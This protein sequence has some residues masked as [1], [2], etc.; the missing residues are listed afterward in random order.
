MRSRADALLDSFWDDDPLLYP[1]LLSDT[2]DDTADSALEEPLP[3]H[4]TSRNSHRKLLTVDPILNPGGIL[5]AHI[6]H[7]YAHRQEG[8]PDFLVYALG[9]LCSFDLNK[10]APGCTFPARTIIPSKLPA[11]AALAVSPLL[12]HSSPSNIAS[13]M[14]VFLVRKADSHDCRVI[15]HPKHLNDAFTPRK[16]RLCSLSDIVW[17]A[18]LFHHGSLET[19]GL[20]ATEAD[21]KNFFP[22]IPVS[23]RL[24][25]Y[26]GVLLNGSFFVQRCLTQGWNG[27]TFCAQSITW[28]ILAFTEKN[29]VD[30]GLSLPVDAVSPPCF[31]TA[32]PTSFP[33]A[34]IA[35]QYDNVLILTGS[36]RDHIAWRDRFMRNCKIF[37]CL[38]KYVN[39]SANFFSFCGIEFLLRDGY[40]FRRTDLERFELQRHL[41]SHCSPSAIARMIQLLLRQGQ[42]CD[43]YPGHPNK[44]RARAFIISQASF[45]GSLMA[46]KTKTDWSTLRPD[47][48]SLH[49]SILSLFRL[50][51]NHWF[52]PHNRIIPDALLIATDARPFCAAWVVFNHLGTIIHAD[53]R[54]FFPSIEISLAETHAVRFAWQDCVNL[55]LFA[56]H[57]FVINGIDNTTASRTLAK[58]YSTVPDNNRIVQDA[59]GLLPIHIIPL[60]VDLHTDRNVADIPTRD[61]SWTVSSLNSSP[62]CKTTFD[63]LTASIRFFSEC[64]SCWMSRSAVDLIGE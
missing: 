8:Q 20:Y 37:N 38:L 57:F 32:G 64:D 45:L 47:L 17:G 49:S 23:G 48:G 5:V 24:A 15:G 40:C 10:L 43:S 7:Y 25:R 18:N 36:H 60:F 58:C 11:P 39:E 44:T 33:R 55:G 26:C 59:L 1:D 2:D 62:L 61:P 54:D 35:V 16:L 41:S 27:S 46:G 31:L 21:F 30:L 56:D 34:F 22:Q 29:D 13:F 19:Q 9:L 4:S 63:I 6:K 52:C 28:A 3:P 50:M 51:R 42:I 14:S 53:R 12:L